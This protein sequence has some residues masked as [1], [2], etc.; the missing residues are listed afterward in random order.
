MV[1][2]KELLSEFYKS[3]VLAHIGNMDRHRHHIAQ[4]YANFFYLLLHLTEDA[5][6]L[7]SEVAGERS[8][9]LVF[10]CQ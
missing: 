1:F 5:T 7:R 4:T 6:N 2:L 3:A 10:R 8:P 9:G